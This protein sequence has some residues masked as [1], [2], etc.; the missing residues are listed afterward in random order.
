MIKMNKTKLIPIV[1]LMFLLAQL[2]VAVPIDTVYEKAAVGRII[3]D[4]PGEMESQLKMEALDLKIYQEMGNVI[5]GLGHY[6]SPMS[7]LIEKFGSN[8]VGYEMRDADS[9]FIDIVA[10]SWNKKPMLVLKWKNGLQSNGEVLYSPGSL[11]SPANLN[12][13]QKASQFT[14]NWKTGFA[15]EN[16]LLFMN[17]EYAGLYDKN[18]DNLLKEIGQDAVTIAPTFYSSKIFPS[19]FGCSIGKYNTLGQTF[20]HARNHYYHRLDD[21][22][23]YLGLTLLSYT[24]YGDPTLMISVPSYNGERNDELCAAFRTPLD[25]YDDQ[26]YIVEFEGEQQELDFEFDIDSMEEPNSTNIV[27]YINIESDSNV[28]HA[29]MQVG[30]E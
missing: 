2:A 18:I 27:G 24:L 20:T 14:S 12:E 22:K 8:N 25:I 19:S 11:I 29:T 30:L 7:A 3:G 5:S 6:D 9:E 4:T 16:P 1:V 23:E 26:R 21:R 28:I 15:K 10:G 13:Y 17:A